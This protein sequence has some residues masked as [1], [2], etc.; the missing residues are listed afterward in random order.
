VGDFAKLE[1]FERAVYGRPRL[2]RLAEN[3][4]A[5]M[6]LHQVLVALREGVGFHP[7]G[8]M[9][10]PEITRTA[11]AIVA[12]FCDPEFKLTQDGFDFI[13]A[14]RVVIDTIFRASVYDGSDFVFSLIDESTEH[15]N[16]YLLLFSI[17]SKTKLDLHEIFSADPQAT[18]G[19]WASLVSYGQVFSPDAHDR[20]EQLLEMAHLFE[21]VIPPASIFNTLCGVYMHC[22]YASGPRKHDCKRVIHKMMVRIQASVA[23][24]DMRPL[25]RSD[26]PRLLVINEWWCSPHAMFRSYSKSIRQLR[27]DFHVIGMKA[28][29]DADI[30]AQEVFDEWVEIDGENMVLCNVAEEI[31]ALRP[32]IIYYPS[33]GMAIWTIAMASL[34]L[35][36][37]QVMTYGHPATSNS[38]EIDY[39][40][41]EAD[42]Y[43]P[44]CFAERVIPLPNNS[45][46]PTA[47]QGVIQRHVPRKTDTIWIGVSAMQ[48]KIS[49]P[50]IKALQEIQER[51]KKTV[52]LWFFSA[53]HGVGLFSLC[54]ELNSLLQNVNTQE[55]QQYDAYM[56]ALHQM[57]IMLFSF[58]FGGANSVYDTLT[59]GVPMVSMEGK[60]P[61]SRSD[62]SIIRRAGLPES[63]IAHSHE[64]YVNAVL[65][66]IDD[67]ERARIAGLVR[68]VDVET[69]F[70]VPDDSN[71]FVDA[72]SR[73]YRENT[74]EMAA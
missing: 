68:A 14:D 59:V 54:R 6:A 38:P 2:D 11:S 23:P 4:T 31:K 44:E 13:A 3:L 33:I 66:L 55:K 16:K 39:G 49:W 9:D 15:L 67:D 35:A 24:C 51:S 65:R 72:F 62:A 1:E 26:K 61:H 41:I 28:G 71:T 18:V 63:L 40:L 48:V 74:L 52:E 43:V 30:A 20:R 10:T 8:H 53:A 57:D 25:V 50:F 37:I 34:R 58:P 46:R 56:E 17:G 60:Q 47:Y 27:R 36:P 19:L 64:E 22:S 42:C 12:L 5:T 69:K 21:D 7:Q 45:V 32:D 29:K 70:Y 73:I